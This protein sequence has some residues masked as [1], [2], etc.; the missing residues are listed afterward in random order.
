MPPVWTYLPEGSR[1]SPSVSLENDLLKTTQD[2]YG[3]SLGDSFA[4][5]D[6]EQLCW[7]TSQVSLLPDLES[8]LVIWPRSGMT[9]NGTAYQLQPLAPLTAAIAFS[10]SLH[11]GPNSDGIWPTAMTQDHSTR[12]AQGGMPLGMAA[13][14]WPTP[15]G[16]DWKGPT[17]KSGWNSVPDAVITAGKL[18]PTPCASDDRD[19]GN[20]ST[21]AIQR[22]AEKGKQ[23]NLSMVVSKTSGNLNPQWVEWLMGFPAGWTD[24]ED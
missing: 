14:L 18:W 9:R 22:R 13:R 21:P 8:S 5:F 2:G 3:Q 4:F 6:H 12:F 10:S 7:K 11:H 1:A 20:L 19:R 15:L 17:G 16:R 23:L 24:L